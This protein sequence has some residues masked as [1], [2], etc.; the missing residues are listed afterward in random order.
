MEVAEQRV[1]VLED[2]LRGHL[3]RRDHQYHFLRGDADLEGLGKNESNSQ[4]K[5]VV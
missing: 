1:P 5:P 2:V 4:S 3:A